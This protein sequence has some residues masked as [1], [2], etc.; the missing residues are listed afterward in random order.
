MQLKVPVKFSY[1]N[2]TWQDVLKQSL[3]EGVEVPG[4]F[5]TVGD[6]VHLNL[7]EA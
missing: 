5:E 3:P 1:E 6:I 2:F 4:G 7:A